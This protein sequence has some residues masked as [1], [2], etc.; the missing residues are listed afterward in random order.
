MNEERMEINTESIRME[1]KWSWTLNNTQ[2]I[3]G[4]TE[5]FH[6]KTSERADDLKHETLRQDVPSIKL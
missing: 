5:V 4:M 3:L 2:H 1:E 6:H